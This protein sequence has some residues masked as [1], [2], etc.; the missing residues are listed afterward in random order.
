[1][2]L[3]IVKLASSPRWLPDVSSPK[4]LSALFAAANPHPSPPSSSPS[5]PSTS[6]NQNLPL[7]T[8]R[9]IHALAG[10]VKEVRLLE[11]VNVIEEPSKLIPLLFLPENPLIDLPL[12]E[13][14]HRLLV[15]PEVQRIPSML[16]SL[17]VVVAVEDWPFEQ[18]TQAG[19]FGDAVPLGRETIAHS[20]H[21]RTAPYE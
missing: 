15:L 7:H 21:V 3:F 17:D 11:I 18:E 5:L 10:H 4:N 20:G 16:R 8:P 1:M 9:G 6:H 13:L 12:L 14:L 19:D 2:P